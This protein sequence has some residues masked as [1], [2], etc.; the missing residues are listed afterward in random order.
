MRVDEFDFELPERLIAL[1]P[2]DPRDSARLLVVQEDGS[3]E[4]RVVRD[5]P[6]LLRPGDVLVVNDSKVVP[7]RLRGTR[8]RADGTENSA[9]VE[10]LL[11]RRTGPSAFRGFARPAKKLKPGDAVLLGRSLRGRVLA[12]DGAEIEMA[13]DTE[14]AELDAAIAA[15]GEMPLPPYIVSRRNADA[16]DREDYQTVYAR[17]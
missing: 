2:V 15:Q 6:E 5:L 1:R 17:E 11:R 16:Q 3:R 9:K 14:G 10:I 7:A 13:F 12:R 8:S 4:D